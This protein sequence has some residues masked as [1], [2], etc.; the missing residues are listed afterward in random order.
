[1]P[2]PY[3]CDF[4]ANNEKKQMG[5][6]Y[7]QDDSFIYFKILPKQQILS[8]DSV[9]IKK[10]ETD[11]SMS[12][13]EKFMQLMCIGFSDSAKYSYNSIKKIHFDL[14]HKKRGISRAIIGLM[15]FSTGIILSQVNAQENGSSELLDWGNAVT[16]IPFS[17]GYFGFRKMTTKNIKT[18]KWN[19]KQIEIDYNFIA[20]Y[21]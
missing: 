2:L 7:K 19:L 17:A 4:I 8:Y 11:T 15:V 9:Q 18:K 3:L 10:I 21:K 14:L 5:V 16:L 20:L 13:S 1:M 6:I 12:K